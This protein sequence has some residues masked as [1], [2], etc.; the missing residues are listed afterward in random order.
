[1]PSVWTR[2]AGELHREY[3][4]N[5]EAFYRAAGRSLAGEL[6]GFMRAAALGLWKNSGAVTESEVASYNSLYS[7]GARPPEAL[8]WD[9]T[10]KVC[11]ADAPR[12]MKARMTEYRMPGPKLKR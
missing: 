2:S 7:K 9:L 8:L 10:G 11:S 3:I 1:M 4:A 6:D 5:T 12:S